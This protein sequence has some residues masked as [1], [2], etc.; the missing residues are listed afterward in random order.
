MDGGDATRHDGSGRH[1]AGPPDRDPAGATGRPSHT[2]DGLR[3][4]TVVG[5]GVA[6][7]AGGA[8]AMAM[9][10]SP[11]RGTAHAASGAPGSPTGADIDDVREELL[12]RWRRVVV[13]GPVPEGHRADH[14]AAVAA[15]DRVAQR[16]LARMDTSPGRGTPWDDLPLDAADS[17]SSHVTA[18]AQRLRAI[19]V[20]WATPGSALHQDTAAA[21]ATAAGIGLLVGSVYREGQ[22]P[23]GNWWDWEIGAPQALLD[24]CALLDPRLPEDTLRRVLA[25]VDH[26]VPDPRR[27]LRGTLVS[28]GANRVDL[29]RIVALR[30]ALGGAPAKLASAASSLAGVLD[31]VP[32]GDGFHP[33][34]S[35]VMHTW[36][37]YTGTYGQV[38][39]RGMV[40]LLRL[41]VS[42]EWEVPARERDRTVAAVTES[43]VPLV[44]GGLMVDAVRGRAVARHQERDADDGFR[45]AV[46]VADLA[47]TLPTTA[48]PTAHRLRAW[49]KAWLTANTY[50]PLAER[51]PAQVATAARLLADD[52][53]RPGREP[54]GHFPFPDME[55]VVHRRRGWTYVLAMNSDRIARFEYMNG[56]NAT[57]WHHGD[58]MAQLHLADDP[59]QYTD[60]YW[61][62]VDP[63]RLPGVTVDTTPLPPGAGGDN[64]H[65]PLTG[66]RFAGMAALADEPLG[67]AALD[68]RGTDSTL[69]ARRSWLFLDD[70][71]LVAGSG[72][73]A[74]G[75]RRVETV[76]DGRHLHSPRRAPRARLTVDGRPQPAALGL[77]VRH[78]RVRWAH[79][80]GVGG[81][82]F[83]TP[84]G[85]ELSTS[86]EDRTGR[87]R[88]LHGSGPTTEVTR[89]HLTLWYDH[90]VDPAGASFAHLLLP[91]V[92]FGAAAARAGSPGVE[93]VA[94][95]QEAHA[96]RTTPGA[97]GGRGG[98]LTAVVFFAAGSAA[99][100]TADG[101][102]AVLVREDGEELR[103]A[104]SDPARQTPVVR[105]E[106]AGSLVGRRRVTRSA[107][108]GLTVLAD[109]PRRGGH[110]AEGPLRLLAETGGG[111]GA[112]LTATLSAGRPHRTRRALL[113]R[114]VADATVR[115]GAHAGENHGAAPTL[116]VHRAATANDT[117][118]AL[119]RFALPAELGEVTRAVLW[120][121][122]H[123]PDDPTTREDD[124]RFTTLAAHGPSGTDW[125][126]SHVTWHTAPAPGPP[127]G[128]GTLTT[129][130]DWVGLEVTAAVRD[131]GRG[132]LSLVLTQREP[133][134]RLVLR[135]RRAPVHVPLL[136]VVTA[137]GG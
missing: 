74:E 65:E 22:E 1:R 30:G 29:C 99:G 21:E 66:T 17:P 37:A 134:H 33:D 124:A 76:V 32:V 42:T 55:R 80:G 85:A 100:V 18:V 39:V 108:P 36:V 3:R 90:G 131:T 88:D 49:A 26:F 97:L 136:Q 132:P 103:L 96:F 23:H 28:T 122:G 24:V 69:R 31:P 113:L 91:G 111:H 82:V 87:W 8:A 129:Y 112:S 73:H 41:L 47:E 16:H 77:T 35:F 34:G 56:E 14:A 75:G 40:A 72:I 50:R 98:R 64:D 125:S 15:A 106:L 95:R 86:R 53:V 102:C 93:V 119:L 120:V 38:L 68:L 27:M 61:P 79:V 59:Y 84:G 67:L 25:A 83:L 109:T 70:A 115:G 116:L 5:V 135:G 71:V 58:G 54:L 11:V 10:A 81:V 126:E 137:G 127:L 51:E 133:G 78:H 92:P 123:I 48:A 62:T 12:R 4:R 2:G 94:L 60:E 43:F 118:R 6:A 13:G 101:P 46:D 45:L 57:G 114:P 44:H 128:E 121:R 89:R 104:V 9:G 20:G 63:K 107:A 130:D 7:A 105:L 110:R 19:A 117:C 52:T